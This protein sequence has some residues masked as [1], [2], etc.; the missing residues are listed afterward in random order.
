MVEDGYDDCPLLDFELSGEVGTSGIYA[1]DQFV[2][3]PN[4]SAS[5]S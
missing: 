5:F 3:R 4:G 2:M 1:E